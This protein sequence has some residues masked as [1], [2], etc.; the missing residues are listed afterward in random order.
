MRDYINKG[1]TPQL[2]K[3]VFGLCLLGLVIMASLALL[4]KC[5]Q[6]DDQ[7]N[8]ASMKDLQRW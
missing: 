2:P 5:F 8:V 6:G 3:K 4:K 7:R 1:T